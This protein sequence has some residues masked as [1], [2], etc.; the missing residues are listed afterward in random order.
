MYIKKM[1]Q[2]IVFFGMLFFQ[3]IANTSV[4]GW[5]ALRVG[6]KKM[7]KTPLF[8]IHFKPLVEKTLQNTVFST[9]S[10]AIFLLNA[11]KTS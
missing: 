9:H 8:A 5:F 1:F 11:A 6:S 3:N 7:K 10:L 2:S 4:F